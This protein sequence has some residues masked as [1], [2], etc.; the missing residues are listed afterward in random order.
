MSTVPFKAEGEIAGGETKMLKVY[1]DAVAGMPM[2]MH[3]HI[4]KVRIVDAR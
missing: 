1:V 4:E 2:G 3:V